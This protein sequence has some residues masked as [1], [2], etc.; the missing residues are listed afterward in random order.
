MYQLQPL[1]VWCALERVAS[2]WERSK[3]QSNAVQGPPPETRVAGVVRQQGFCVGEIIMQGPNVQNFKSFEH[4]PGRFWH[5]HWPPDALPYKPSVRHQ[6]KYVLRICLVIIKKTAS[7]S[8]ARQA[9][10]KCPIQVRVRVS[11]ILGPPQGTYATRHGRLP[12]R[13]PAPRALPYATRS[14][15][16]RVWVC[17]RGACAS[18]AARWMD[19]TDRNSAS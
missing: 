6:V 14:Q 8:E 16:W 19:P 10:R 12:R 5:W 17:R 3:G 15:P 4:D 9:P 1:Q 18:C 7:Q 13:S 2:G 11:N